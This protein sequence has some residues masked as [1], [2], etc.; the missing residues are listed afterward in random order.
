M[1]NGI[2]KKFLAFVL[3]TAMIVTFM[4]SSVFTLADDGSADAAAVQEDAAPE[5]AP[6]EEKVMKKA[7]APDPVYFHPDAGGGCAGDH[8]HH[9]DPSPADHA[10]GSEKH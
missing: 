9:D 6:S 5:K 2:L 7:E 8:K 1:K 4:P 10:A 3:C